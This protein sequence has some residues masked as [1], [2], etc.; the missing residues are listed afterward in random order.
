MKKLTETEKMWNV[1]Q[2]IYDDFANQF[3]FEFSTPN[4]TTLELIYLLDKKK[5]KAELLRVMM[6][7]YLS[8]LPDDKIIVLNKRIYSVSEMLTQL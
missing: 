2:K 3:E 6:E 8:N 1:G 7:E 5:H 4:T